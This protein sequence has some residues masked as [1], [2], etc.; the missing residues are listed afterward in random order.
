MYQN[1]KTDNAATLLANHSKESTTIVHHPAHLEPA[2]TRKPDHPVYH[3]VVAYSSPD[4]PSSS[5]PRGAIDTSIAEMVA[6]SPDANCQLTFEHMDWEYLEK[7]FRFLSGNHTTPGWVWKKPGSQDN[8]R[9]RFKVL[10][11]SSFTPIHIA[12]P[13]PNSC[14][15]YRMVCFTRVGKEGAPL[16]GTGGELSALLDRFPDLKISGRIESAAGAG[17]IRGYKF[18]PNDQGTSDEIKATAERSLMWEHLTTHSN[19][20]LENFIQNSALQEAASPE[21]EAEVLAA[22]KI[23]VD[24]TDDLTIYRLGM[25][26]TNL[27]K[28]LARVDGRLE[29]DIIDDYE[30]E[31][32]LHLAKCPGELDL[33]GLTDLSEKMA[34]AFGCRVGMLCL[35]GITV[36]SLPAACALSN[37]RGYLSLM[38]IHGAPP[39]VIRALGQHKGST[40]LNGLYEI[41]DSAADGF[42]FHIGDLHLHKLTQIS[43]RLAECLATNDGGLYLDGLTTL[44][45]EIAE[46][47]SHHCGELRLR[48]LRSLSDEACKHLGRHKGNLIFGRELN[49]V[50]VQ[51]L[52]ALAA[53]GGDLHLNGLKTLCPE[54]AAALAKHRGALHLGGLTELD[55]GI[56]EIISSHAGPLSFSGVFR[57]LCPAAARALSRHRGEL[58]LKGLQTLVYPMAGFLES[59]SGPIYIGRSFKDSPDTAVH[60]NY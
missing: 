58:H 55:P 51:G 2:N 50:S 16:C 33:L 23:L 47:L 25:L 21:K 22:A 52:N 32:A 43:Q 45:E 57:Y 59:H 26:S 24:R 8:P 29:I 14:S 19:H 38:S 60:W 18:T 15:D 53:N 17:T 11:Q 4:L 30:E 40:V 37:H 39:D 12:D 34:G 10:T 44:S 35:D 46:A 20:E 36:L 5:S 42:E 28:I 31:A 41:P 54:G 7:F 3:D 48:G 49:Q 13:V 56:A 1:T 6:S 9:D 27:A